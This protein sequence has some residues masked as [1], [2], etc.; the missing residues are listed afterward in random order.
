LARKAFR[1]FT[2]A[3]YVDRDL[4]ADYQE[5]LTAEQRSAYS[6]V[7]SRMLDAYDSHNQ[8]PRA[9]FIEL[10]TDSMLLFRR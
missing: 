7:A 8:S 1:F 9:M 10:A 2:D 3:T 4:D 6:C 5:E